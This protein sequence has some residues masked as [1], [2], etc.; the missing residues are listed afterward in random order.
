MALFG[1]LC[2]LPPIA[3]ESHWNFVCL[4]IST[5]LYYFAIT[6][7]CTPYNALIS[8]YGHDKTERLNIATLVSVTWALGFMLGN[9]VYLFQSM[10]QSQF[11][12]WSSEQCFQ[13]VV[14]AFQLISL[15][16]MILPSI[17]IKES[18]H[19]RST[20][21]EEK[22]IDSVKM[23]FSNRN[24]RFFSRLRFLLLAFG[25]FYSAGHQLLHNWSTGLTQRIGVAPY[26][27]T[28]STK[29]CFLLP[30]QCIQ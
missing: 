8:E 15:V 24:F 27:S 13:A 4:L 5:L 26:D 2:F 10:L 6:A 30:S 14:I 16:L 9:Q 22:L 20:I 19:A 23:T 1:S 11:T 28:V 29:L 21:S 18:Q 17:L 3:A 25:K 12:N 7:Y